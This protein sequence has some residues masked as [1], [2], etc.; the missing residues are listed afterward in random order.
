MKRVLRIAFG[1]PLCIFPM[2]LG[3]YV[4]MWTDDEDSWWE[5]PGIL[6]WWLASGQWEKLPD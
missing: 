1:L 3:T 6:T 2:L 5:G 4:W